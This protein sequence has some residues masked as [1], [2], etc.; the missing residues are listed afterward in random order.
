MLATYGDSLPT[1]DTNLFTTL[2][3]YLDFNLEKLLK[4]AT[5]AAQD[6]NSAESIQLED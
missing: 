3:K 4:L 2:P 6:L 5:F 1:Q